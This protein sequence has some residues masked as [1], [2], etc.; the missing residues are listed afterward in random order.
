MSLKKNLINFLEYLEIEKNRSPKTVENY[1]FYLGRFIEWF[2]DKSAD[3]IKSEDVRQYRLWLNRLVDVHG[4]A[5]KKN[6]QNYHL[7]ALRSFLKYLSKQDVETLAPEKIEL[8]KMPDRQVDF[9]DNSDLN[10]ILEAPFK[11][12]NKKKLE[13]EGEKKGMSATLLIAYR[14][15]ALLE[16]LFST[17][18]RVSEAAKLKKT[19]INLN[20]DEFTVRGKG[21]KSRIVFLSEQAKY[22]LKKYLEIRADM[23]PHLFISHDKRTKK[24]DNDSFLTP[25]SIERIVQKHAREAGITK[26]VTPHTLRHSYATDLLQN[27]A[28]IRSVQAMLGHS[29]ITT[30]QIYTHITDKELRNIHK[31]FHDK[32]RK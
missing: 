10:R 9:L 19:D 30:T 8:M 27:G 17:G 13:E 1:N 21:M 23:N 15:K 20:R 25:R 18:L 3:A 31:K 12:I 32:G 6:T 14:D 11:N 2:G 26:T 16:L 28:D 24:E 29:S 4:E 5:L 7:I 22:F